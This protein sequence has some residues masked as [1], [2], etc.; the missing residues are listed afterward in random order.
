M[1]LWSLHPIYLDDIGLSRCY[2]EGIGGLKA[3]LGLQK[4]H[5]NHPQLIRFKER[6]NP[7]N[8]LSYYLTC[9]YTSALDRNKRYKYGNLITGWRVKETFLVPVTKG[10]IEFE[11]KWLSV[12]KQSGRCK[13]GNGYEYIS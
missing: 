9:V 2:Y 4:M 7:V 13:K 12:K 8:D 3:M 6:G 11:V 5:K 1:R 10:Q